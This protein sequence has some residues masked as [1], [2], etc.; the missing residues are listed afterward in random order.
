MAGE[1]A[2]SR[3]RSGQHNVRVNG[4]ARY[5]IDFFGLSR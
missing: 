1:S 2:F 5:A 3:F 4:M